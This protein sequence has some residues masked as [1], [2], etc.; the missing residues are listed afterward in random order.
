MGGPPRTLSHAWL[1]RFEVLRGR[2]VT[3]CPPQKRSS[4][5]L[6][7]SDCRSLLAALPSGRSTALWHQW[8]YTYTAHQRARSRP[9]HAYQTAPANVL[10]D[11]PEFSPEC[12]PE[13]K[14]KVSP[15]PGPAITD[16]TRVKP[17]LW[18]PKRTNVAGKP[19]SNS[20]RWVS[21]QPARIHKPKARPSR[22]EHTTSEGSGLCWD[23]TFSSGP[24]K[25]SV[26]R[27]T[28]RTMRLG[29]GLIKDKNSR[30]GVPLANHGRGSQGITGYQGLWHTFLRLRVF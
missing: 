27:C 26:A 19:A 25:M 12:I 9:R 5:H 14:K 6:F 24:P 10:R 28:R 30:N 16:R 13:W 17:S 7:Q 15:C 29:G 18:G 22:T 1:A 2:F 3:P 23:D 21:R 11:I 8:P 4:G 20:P